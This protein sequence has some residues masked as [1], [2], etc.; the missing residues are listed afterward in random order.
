MTS[1]LREIL[2]RVAY[3]VTGKLLAEQFTPA[4]SESRNLVLRFAAVEASCFARNCPLY[5]VLHDALIH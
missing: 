1:A 4:V 5:G 2:R 3:R